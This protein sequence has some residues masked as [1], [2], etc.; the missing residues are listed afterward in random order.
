MNDERV[1]ID[2]AVQID[3]IG[4]SFKRV[5]ICVFKH[6]QQIN[7]NLQRDNDPANDEPH[8]LILSEAQDLIDE[9]TKAIK[10]LG[11]PND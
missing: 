3:L 8:F 4:A 1:I 11:E 6:I 2:G 9:L 10:T 5:N 7:L